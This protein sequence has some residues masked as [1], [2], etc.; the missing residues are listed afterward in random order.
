V[1]AR[2]SAFPVGNYYAAK[3]GQCLPSHREWA[4]VVAT[5]TKA[6]GTYIRYHRRF[7]STRLRLN[8]KHKRGVPEHSA[9]FAL[10]TPALRGRNTKGRSTEVCA[11]QHRL[12]SDAGT[13]L[14]LSRLIMPSAK[15]KLISKRKQ[16]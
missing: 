14:L 7:R 13:Q 1:R 9:K 12:L 4:Q 16:F 6:P 11:A 2:Q 3:R 5:W 10:M 15:A 8:A